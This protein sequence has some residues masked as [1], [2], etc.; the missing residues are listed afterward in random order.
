MSTDSY[1]H[2]G[3]AIVGKD[4]FIFDFE[5][6]HKPDPLIGD[7]RPWFAGVNI[8]QFMVWGYLW[9]ELQ[10]LPDG[11]PQVFVFRHKSQLDQNGATEFEAY[12]VARAVAKLLINDDRFC[13]EDGITMSVRPKIIVEGIVRRDGY[14]FE[15]IPTGKSGNETREAR[16]A[17][18]SPSIQ[19]G[20]R[21]LGN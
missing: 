18:R 4:K 13:S 14:V 3:G 10:R 17:S 1:R 5:D 19:Y 20:T 12:L 6:L 16:P 7:L 8:G 15:P 11:R 21:P 9:V 2:L